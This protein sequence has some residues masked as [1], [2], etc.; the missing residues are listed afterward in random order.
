M[1]DTRRNYLRRIM[2]L[3]WDLFRSDPTR[4]F[5]DALRGSW[6]FIRATAK[7]SQA[8]RARSR[9]ARHVMLSPSLIHSPASRVTSTQRYPGVADCRAGITISR[10]GA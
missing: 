9:G 1:T 8:F 6:K 5:A 2:G 10:I 4:T 3:A 7:A